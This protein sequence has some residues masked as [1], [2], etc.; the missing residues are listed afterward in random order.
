MCVWLRWSERD[1]RRAIDS[2]KLTDQDFVNFS[3]VMNG[4]CLACCGVHLSRGSKFNKPWQKSMNDALLFNSGNQKRRQRHLPDC[5]ARTP[6]FLHLRSMPRRFEVRHWGLV[7]YIRESC[8]LEV[9]LSGLLVGVPLPRILFKRLQTVLLVVNGVAIGVSIRDVGI[10]VEEVPC[11]FPRVHHVRRGHPVVT[12]QH[13]K[14]CSAKRRN[15][16]SISIILVIWLYSLVPGKRG[17]PRNSSTAIQ[18]NDHM[19]I[20]ALYGIPSNTSGD[21]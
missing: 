7:D 18:P 11:L 8:S 3:P 12:D 17:N 4:C 13:N 6:T 5:P 20:A 19:S 14:K 10:R 16:P 1:G 21:L 15:Y 2:H 9:L